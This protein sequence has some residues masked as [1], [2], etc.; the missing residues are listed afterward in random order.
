QRQLI[1]L[2]TEQNAVEHVAGLIGRYGIGSLAQ[3][4][5]Q[6]FLA[7]RDHFCLLEFR[8]R[9]KFVF[10]QPENLEEALAAADRS[11][12]FSIHIDLNFTRRQF[13]NDIEKASR[14]ESSRSRFVY[15]RFATAA[16]A[17]IKIG[18]GKMDFVFIGLQQNIGKDW[19]CRAGADDV[20]DL[21][22]TLEQFFFR[23]AK[24]HDERKRLR[25]KAFDFVRQAAISLRQ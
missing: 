4:I 16:H 25:C 1:V 5:A 11:G 8:Q 18:S 3:A 12:I 17:D 19:E 24:F 6:I 22:Q 23:N 14:R 7:N 20:L 15:V 21:L 10:R 2:E 9:R 13:A